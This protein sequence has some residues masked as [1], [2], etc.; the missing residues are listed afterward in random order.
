[1]WRVLVIGISKKKKKGGLCEYRYF[2][3]VF[4]LRA[5][6]WHR[7]LS[8]KP[9]T[10]AFAP[11]SEVVFFFLTKNKM[12]SSASGLYSVG[13]ARLS[14]GRSA[15][16]KAAMFQPPSADLHPQKERLAA[17]KPVNRV[18]IVPQHP[19]RAV[20][21]GTLRWNIITQ[22]QECLVSPRPRRVRFDAGLEEESLM[23]KQTSFLTEF[24]GSFTR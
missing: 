10:M 3:S 15:R 24:W 5:A 16:K 22:S 12:W 13:C 6:V 7:N 11:P 20:S 18:S 19:V 14:V 8:R 4:L 17:S 9:G 2:E 23:K 1:M 21:S